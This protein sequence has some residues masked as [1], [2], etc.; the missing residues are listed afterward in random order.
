M[1]ACIATLVKLH[2]IRYKTGLHSR[3]G[4]IKAGGHKCQEP[5]AFGGPGRNIVNATPAAYN[6]ED[7]FD[8]LA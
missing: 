2:T 6:S 4:W 1:L 7:H 8:R 5:R 3:Q